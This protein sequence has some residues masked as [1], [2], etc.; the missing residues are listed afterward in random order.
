MK[1]SQKSKNF[2]SIFCCIFKI[3]INFVNTLAANEM[4]PVLNRGNLKIPI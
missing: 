1:L 4:Y 2:F 3:Y